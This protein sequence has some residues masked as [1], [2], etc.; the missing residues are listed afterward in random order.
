MHTEEF[1]HEVSYYRQEMWIVWLTKVAKNCQ[2]IILNCGKHALSYAVVLA[3]LLT[4]ETRPVLQA[5]VVYP[6]I[7]LMAVLSQPYFVGIGNGMMMAGEL[8]AAINR[9]QVSSPVTWIS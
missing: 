1:I 6:A 9:M 4:S 5:D 8:H 7:A 3:V 2:H